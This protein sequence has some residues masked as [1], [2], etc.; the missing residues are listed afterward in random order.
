MRNYNQ[1]PVWSGVVLAGI[2]L[3]PRAGLTHEKTD[4]FAIRTTTK[5]VIAPLK[6]IQDLSDRFYAGARASKDALLKIGQ[7]L[8]RALDGHEWV[9]T[10]NGHHESE[11]NTGRGQVVLSTTRPGSEDELGLGLH[12]SMTIVGGLHSDGLLADFFI[13]G[14]NLMLMDRDAVTERTQLRRTTGTYTLRNRLVLALFGDQLDRSFDRKAIDPAL[15]VSTAVHKAAQDGWL[16][17]DAGYTYAWEGGIDLTTYLVAR[18]ER[19]NP[20]NWELVSQVHRPTEGPMLLDIVRLLMARRSDFA[21]EVRQSLAARVE[22]VERANQA[23]KEHGTPLSA[24]LAK[25]KAQMQ[26]LYRLDQVYTTLNLSQT[27]LDDVEAQLGRER[28]HRQGAAGNL[29]NLFETPPTTLLSRSRDQTRETLRYILSHV[30]MIGFDSIIARRLDAVPSAQE[31]AINDYIRTPGTGRVLQD[32][33]L[34]DI[35]QLRGDE[36]AAG[37]SLLFAHGHWRQRHNAAQNPADLPGGSAPASVI[38]LGRDEVAAAAT[39]DSREI[40]ID[41]LELDKPKQ[42][43]LLPRKHS[44]NSQ[45]KH[46]VGQHAAPP[47]ILTTRKPVKKGTVVVWASDDLTENENVVRLFQSA[48]ERVQ[49]RLNKGYRFEDG[50]W[51]SPESGVAATL[52]RKV[53]KPEPSWEMIVRAVV[54]LRGNPFAVGLREKPEAEWSFYDDAGFVAARYLGDGEWEVHGMTPPGGDKRVSEDVAHYDKRVIIGSDGPSQKEGVE[55]SGREAADE[56]VGEIRRSLQKD[57]IAV[58]ER[59][60]TAGR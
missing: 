56:V 19:G 50:V 18:D 46:A 34:V 54:E 30:D 11:Y 21:G 6:H 26:L 47:E 60:S 13:R 28:A 15:G 35:Q 2:C 39:G 48:K 45:L 16:M 38:I 24:E 43:D 59:D 25:I 52:L 55:I 12:P 1:R 29:A 20:H 41:D 27:S 17:G 7:G 8:G 49:S 53:K 40:Q 14:A 4:R 9:D 22:E 51:K 57:G 10:G 36:R 3:T 44:H 58:S 42:N 5:T 33:K 23:L 31:R 37:K 32:G